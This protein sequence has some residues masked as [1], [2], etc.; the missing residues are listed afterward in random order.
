[1]GKGGGVENAHKKHEKKEVK[2]RGV[3]GRRRKTKQKGT[4]RHRKKGK[5]KNEKKGRKYRL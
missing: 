2:M 1:L 3:G 4:F 5:S